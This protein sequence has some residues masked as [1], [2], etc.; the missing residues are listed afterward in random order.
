MAYKV[1]SFRIL[2]G[3]LLQATVSS[4]DSAVTLVHEREDVGLVFRL[5]TRKY[6]VVRVGFACLQELGFETFCV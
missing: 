5:K 2:L 4:P 6:G 3:S 1:G